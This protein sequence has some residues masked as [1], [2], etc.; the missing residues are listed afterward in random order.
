MDLLE[1]AIIDS[2]E[3]MLTYFRH[4]HLRGD[5]REASVPFAEH[6]IRIVTRYP[7]GPER[8]VGLRKL[9][10]AKDCIVRCALDTMNAAAV[11]NANPKA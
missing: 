5:L 9:L 3:R 2:K 10:E 6:A 4:E 7:P 1:Q 8:T 11:E